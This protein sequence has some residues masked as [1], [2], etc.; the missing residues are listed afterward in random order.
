MQKIIDF[1]HRHWEEGWPQESHDLL[2]EFLE[3]AERYPKKA[4]D[5][6]TIRAP[7]IR[8]DKGVAFTALIHPSNPDSGAYGGMSFV[9]FPIKDGPSMIAMVIGTQGNGKLNSLQ[10]GKSLTFTPM[11]R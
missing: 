10:L 9:I 4:T 3:G 7:D 11:I 8:P 2:Q 5:N 6:A 1:I